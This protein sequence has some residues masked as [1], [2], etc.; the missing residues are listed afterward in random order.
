MTE[1]QP[2]ARTGR[3]LCGSVTFSFTPKTAEVDVCHCQM[4][5]RW[6]GG[7][8]F[9]IMANGSP[10]IE[11]AENITE[12]V[13]S[14]WGRRHFCTRC[15]SN[16]FY[17][18]PGYGYFGVCAGAIDDPAGLQ[19]TME[20]FIDAQPDYYSFAQQTKR[21]TEAEFTAKIAQMMA[22][23]GDGTGGSGASGGGEPRD[24]NRSADD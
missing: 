17:T 1:I 12:F 16:L 21:L 18:A 13:S 5:Q 7:P 22:G 20:I 11:G 15:G 24:G 2:E 6:N 19:M 23:G 10:E 8:G 4:C 14:D 3:C 9:S